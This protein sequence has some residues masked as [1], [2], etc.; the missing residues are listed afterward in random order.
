MADHM[1]E[2]FAF[3]AETAQ[4]MSL[5]TDQ[6]HTIYSNKKIFLVCLSILYFGLFMLLSS[7][8]DHT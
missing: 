2:T 8:A 7:R 4:L 3:Q 5:I 1:E 6:G